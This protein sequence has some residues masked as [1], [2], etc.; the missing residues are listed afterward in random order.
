MVRTIR[1]PSRE[2]PKL[3]AKMLSTRWCAISFHY[4][5]EYWNLI[6]E[7]ASR[8]FAAM[9]DDIV[10]D[11]AS[12][13]HQEVARSKRKCEACYT[14]CVSIDVLFNGSLICHS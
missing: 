3:S 11:V 13:S 6:V 8:L 2:W 5:R 4:A 14:Q 1:G 7:Q 12:Q 10:V 9:L